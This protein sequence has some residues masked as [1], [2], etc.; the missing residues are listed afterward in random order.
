MRRTKRNQGK[1]FLIKLE[2]PQNIHGITK[3]TEDLFRELLE[4]T[5][6]VWCFLPAQLARDW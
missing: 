6:R 3:E 4:V 2:K 1:G 5:D